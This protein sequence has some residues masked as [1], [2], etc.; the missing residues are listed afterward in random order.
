MPS[1]LWCVAIQGTL[2][3]LRLLIKVMA[4]SILMNKVECKFP[5]SF[6]DP[7]WSKGEASFFRAQLLCFLGNCVNVFITMATTPCACKTH[8]ITS[9]YLVPRACFIKTSFCDQHPRSQISFLD[10]VTCPY[11]KR[12]ERGMPDKSNSAPSFNSLLFP[13]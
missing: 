3:T 7:E 12:Q 2:S 13:R 4:V 10:T 9:F 11:C 8:Q 1:S 6:I 5:T